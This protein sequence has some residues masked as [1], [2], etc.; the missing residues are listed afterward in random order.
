MV[1]WKA[2]AG[3]VGAATSA[4]VVLAAALDAAS[5]LGNGLPAFAAIVVLGC[6]VFVVTYLIVRNREE[7]ARS[8][9]FEPAGPACNPGPY[10]LS[11]GESKAIRLRIRGGER[12]AGT[13]TSAFTDEDFDF[14]ILNH[15]GVARFER[16]EF[17]R[18]ARQGKGKTAY[19]VDWVAPAGGPWYLELS[20]RARRVK[21]RIEVDL[22]RSPRG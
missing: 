1:K 13:L 5:L 6:A 3:A 10:T 20:T 8:E 4:I 11:P 22:E 9:Q 21:R 15:D 7:P 17:P 18:S 16:G 2:L 19:S 12:L 14:A